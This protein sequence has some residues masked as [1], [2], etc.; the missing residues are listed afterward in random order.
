MRTMCTFEVC[1]CV[2]YMSMVIRKYVNK[3]A[4]WL[5][6]IP[7]IDMW[8]RLFVSPYDESTH[9]RRPHTSVCLGAPRGLIHPWHHRYGDQCNWWNLVKQ[10]DVKAPVISVPSKTSAESYAC[11]WYINIYIIYLFQWFLCLW[12]SYTSLTAGSV[13]EGLTKKIKWM[14]F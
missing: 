2:K 8:K 10:F 11:L 1:S 14:I 12:Q 3:Q 6:Q 7:W 5:G 13:K 9:A 4:T